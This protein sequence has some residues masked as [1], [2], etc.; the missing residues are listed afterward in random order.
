[1]SNEIDGT[2]IP[3][4]VDNLV[5]EDQPT[6]SGKTREA[7][8]FDQTQ[9]HSEVHGRRVQRDYAA[10]FFRWGWV[11]RNWVKPG[12]TILDIGA[13]QDLP[14]LYVMSAI[15]HRGL[16]PARYVAV[17]LNPLP[18]VKR[19]WATLLG[20]FCLHERWHELEL[21]PGMDQRPGPEDAKFN[22]LKGYDLI[23]CL[24]VIEHMA[25]PDGLKL[26]KIAY[27]LLSPGGRF[28]LSTPVYDGR[29]RA[30]NHIHEYGITELKECVEWAGFEVERR[31]GTFANKL[32]LLR[33]MAPEHQKVYQE[34]ETYYGGEVMSTF[35]APLYPNVSRNNLWVLRRKP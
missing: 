1:M 18:E 13:G 21:I 22:N 24:E 7:R 4:L 27:D 25:K 5:L 17:D 29:A 32:D 12:M 35:M 6:R 9:L 8:R 16:L 3:D 14:F 28:M 34:L 2:T 31:F 30:L 26:L 33:V 11:A 15:S 20:E 23:M 10:H 19:P